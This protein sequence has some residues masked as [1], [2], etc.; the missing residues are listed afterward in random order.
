MD[1]ARAV[2]GE[3]RGSHKT[4]LGARE[5]AHSVNDRKREGRREGDVPASPG[6]AVLSTVACRPRAHPGGESC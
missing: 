3:L 2:D 5:P 1:S 6:R 4:G